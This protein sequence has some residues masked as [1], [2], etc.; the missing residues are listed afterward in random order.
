VLDLLIVDGVI[1]GSQSDCDGRIYQ[2]CILIGVGEWQRVTGGSCTERYSGR[3]MR[4]L[5]GFDKALRHYADRGGFTVYFV[6][7]YAPEAIE[8]LGPAPQRGSKK[9]SA[10]HSD[11]LPD[12]PDSQWPPSS[13]LEEERDTP[14]TG[15]E[16]QEQPKWMFA[17]GDGDFGEHQPQLLA[18]RIVHEDDDFNLPGT[19]Q[20]EEGDKEGPPAISLPLNMV[21]LRALGHSATPARSSFPHPL[22]LCLLQGVSESDDTP[23]FISFCNSH[24]KLWL[25]VAWLDYDSHIVMRRLL[26]PGDSYFEQSFVSHPWIARAVDPQKR[27]K[28]DV[29][30]SSSRVAPG[31][32]RC[33]TLRLGDAV[34]ACSS[35]LSIL[36]D[37]AAL[38]LSVM[39]QASKGPV[40]ATQRRSKAVSLLPGVDDAEGE[41]L[42]GDVMGD[43]PTTS[44]HGKVQA[45]KAKVLHDMQMSRTLPPLGAGS[46]GA[47]R[48]GTP[49]VKLVMLG[50]FFPT[51]Y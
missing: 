45:A 30:D 25:Q 46:S 17:T 22:F 9:D 21:S 26:Q 13:F 35:S 29:L 42:W 4:S 41:E 47:P 23:V 7:R 12:K 38:S 18:D 10:S 32:G 6:D 44:L 43:L 20:Q 16:S 2:G 5:A 3:I 48:S 14:F 24:S 50:S 51:G 1:P 28:E 15:E 49:H 31:A 27:G 40:A 8:V 33:L 11:S 36:W 39:S 37:P 19:V 34:A